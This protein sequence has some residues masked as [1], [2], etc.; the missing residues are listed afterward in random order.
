MSISDKKLKQINEKYNKKLNKK[1][2]QQINE[3][4]REE[5]I[6][7]EIST[8]Y[9]VFHKLKKKGEK[10]RDDKEILKMIKQIR[11]EEE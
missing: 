1:Y 6:I 10:C 7:P 2:G 3:K 5:Y 9:L 4:D 11:N 8:Q